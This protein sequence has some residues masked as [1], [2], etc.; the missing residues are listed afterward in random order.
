MKKA[1]LIVFSILIIA[2]VA[3]TIIIK[4]YI[5]PEKVKSF[6]VP[7][8]E[9]TLGRKVTVG[10]IKI[11]L[12][13][14]IEV[15]DLAIKEA[16]GSTDFLKSGEFVLK[17]SL[18]PLLSK[19]VVINELRIISPDLRIIRDKDGKYNFESIGRSEETGEVKE[20]AGTAEPGGLPVSL[21]INSI[22][23]KDSSFTFI[24]HKEELPDVKG[25]INLNT[26]ITG[27]GNNKLS[28][29][30]NLEIRLD[31]I[32]TRRPEK[33]IR[34][35]SADLK[36]EVSIDLESGSLR[37][38]KADI[39]FQEIPFSLTGEANYKT[40]TEID[41]NL[42]IPE[43]KTANILK[44][45]SPFVDTG[46]VTL[47]GGLSADLKVR[48]NPGKVDSLITDGEIRLVKV[49]AAR[50]NISAVLDGNV[51]L[52][53]D[54]LDIDI[55]CTVGENAATLKGTVKSYLKDQRVS[56]NLYSKMLL[57]DELIP[58]AGEKTTAPVQE[59]GQAKKKAGT[60]ESKPLDLKITAD[61][62]VTIDSAIYKG[63][64]M[65]NF[66]MTYQFINNRLEI[67]DMSAIAGKGK[68]NLKSLIDLSKPGYIYNLSSSIDSLH[69]DEVI[70]SL[71]P[72]AKNTVFGI[73]SLNLALNG[74]GTLTDNVKKNL[75]GNGDFN[76]MGGKI[77]NSKL[78]ETLSTFL[79][80]EELRT[81]DFN[82]AKGTVIIKNGAVK[83][84][85]IFSSDDLSM[86]PSGNIRL[87]ETLDLAFDLK[88]SP[89]LT[90]KAM[91]NSSIASYIKDEKEWGTIP[92]KVSGTFSAPSYSIDAAKAGKRVIEK[93]AGKLLEDILNK[94]KENTEKNGEEKDSDKSLEDVLKKLF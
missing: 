13:K 15:R 39:L 91:L 26:G 27:T 10:E 89:R 63:L 60:E 21:L 46:G 44:S 81:I 57:L 85:S 20:K 78:P 2:V 87:D 67:K 74:A 80:I 17:Y 54:S 47:S 75:A 6:L 72:E 49:G 30:G 53:E 93:K 86:D 70:N 55:N 36:Y 38:Q 41:I 1:L 66:S 51:K 3:L 61:G 50:D 52:R 48:G 40:T 83:L 45:V 35:I 64:K 90:D 56:L 4:V 43:T 34:D 16:D 62:K 37:I 8:A 77:T 76:I 25:V 68:F 33:L 92:L 31:E 24:D 32:K 19:K 5:T 18:L 65:N 28:S 22:V 12:L 88:L 29:K 58:A 82:E 71:F 79:G 84:Q 7:V 42:L 23:L 94:N 73:L 9:N 69:A 59:S 14:G 11:G